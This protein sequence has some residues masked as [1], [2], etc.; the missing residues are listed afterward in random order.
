MD[1]IIGHY[2]LNR[3]SFPRTSRFGLISSTL[4]QASANPSPQKTSHKKRHTKPCRYYQV[5]KCPHKK[6]ED[7]DFAMSSAI[8]LVIVCNG[9]WCQYLHGEATV[10]SDDH[11]LLKDYQNA[12]YAGYITTPNSLRMNGPISPTIYV[13]AHFVHAPPPWAHP[14]DFVPPH[15]Q[16]SV[17][18]YS[19]DFTSPVSS[20]TSSLSEDGVLLSEDTLGRNYSYFGAEHQNPYIH[21][22]DDSYSYLPLSPVLSGYGMASMYE[23]FSPKSPSSSAGFYSQHRSAVDR[24]RQRQLSYRTKPCRYFRAGNTCPSGNDLYIFVCFWMR[25]LINSLPSLHAEMKMQHDLPP[26]PLSAK[27]RNNRKGFF[28]I[29]WRVIGGGV[30]VSGGAKAEYSDDGACDVFDDSLEIPIDPVAADRRSIAIPPQPRQRKPSI[31]VTNTNRGKQRVVRRRPPS[32]KRTLS[33]PSTPIATHREN[34][35]FL[36]RVS[37]RFVGHLT[38]RELYVV[39]LGNFMIDEQISRRTPEK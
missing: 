17:P 21:S 22:R 33:I 14:I 37:G 39:F 2:T 9:V 36:C 13:P 11:S 28:P 19:T 10:G 23:P 5:G 25:H 31:L 32:H 24:E 30:L 3:A 26:K 34:L 1:H 29:P 35:P 18:S 7:C 38:L 20:P 8:C 16:P 6:Q 4:S 27:E 15:L 12:S